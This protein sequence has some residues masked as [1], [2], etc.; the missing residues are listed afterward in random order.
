[1]QR[2]PTDVG[3]AIETATGGIGTRAQVVLALVQEQSRFLPVTEIDG[4]TIGNGRRGGITTELQ[5]RFDQL[6]L[7]DAGV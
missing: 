4:R 7:R 2:E 3:E 1:L 5:A 6:E